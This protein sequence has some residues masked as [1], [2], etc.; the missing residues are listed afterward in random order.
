MNRELKLALIIGFSLVLLVTV[1][2]SDHLSKARKADL[3]GVETARPLAAVDPTAHPSMNSEPTV[4]RDLGMEPDPAPMSPPAA[5]I[6]LGPAP[7][8]MAA[9]IALTPSPPLVHFDQSS[10]RGVGVDGDAGLVETIRSM[11]GQVVNRDGDREVVLPPAPLTIVE[12]KP[13]TNDLKHIVV[14][15]DSLFSIAKKH[16][17]D[18]SAW[19]RIRD[20]NPDRVSETGVVRT[21][22]T[23]KIPAP[24]PA[25][26]PAGLAMPEP[27]RNKPRTPEARPASRSAGDAV[28]SKVKTGTYTVRRGDTLGEIAQR[29]LGSTRRKGE[30]MKLN[31]IDNEDSIRVGAVLRLPE[32]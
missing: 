1:L 20:A 21:G 29:V 2:V 17:G 28:A 4:M 31:N 11:G 7:A 6:A 12:P 3:A 23:L 27:E 25:L 32:R 14:N 30:L 18:G 24:Q 8:G 13:A 16:Y 10:G 26:R 5:P 9:G 15:G 19:K 22:V